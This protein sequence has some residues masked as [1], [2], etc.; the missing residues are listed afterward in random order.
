MSRDDD[1]VGPSWFRWTVI[2]LGEI[3]RSDMLL[4]LSGLRREER[5]MVQASINNERDLD[6]VA[7][8]LI[9]Q[10]PRIHLRESQRQSK[11]KG[12]DGSKRGDTSSTRWFRGKG[13]GKHT[14]SGEPVQVS[15]TRISITLMITI[16]TTTCRNT[17]MPIKLTTIRLT[18]A[19]TT[20]MKLWTT[21]RK[22]DTFS[23]YVARDDVT[24]HEAAELDVIA[25]LADT[26]D[27]DLDPEVSAQLVE[28][29]VLQAHLSFGKEQGKGKGKG[30]GKSKGRYPVRPSHLS[31]EDRR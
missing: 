1:V 8:A 28:A 22:N 10:H 18:L 15:T 12:K 31:L 14:G 19:V 27:N 23:T 9:I 30:K 17:K 3:Y 2:H 7:E 25:L 16:L 29:T 6:R 5:V 4:D 20:E 11:G 21:M 24:A 26:W 13:E